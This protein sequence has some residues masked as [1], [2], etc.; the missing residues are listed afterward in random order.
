MLAVAYIEEEKMPNLAITADVAFSIVLKAREFDEKVDQTDPDSSSNP[1]DD[2]SIDALEF[3][4]HDQTR[5][6]L[7]SAI[8]DLNDDEQLDI[9]ALI[10]L[11]RGDFTL[12]EWDDAR[13][14]ATEIGR[15]GTPRFVVGIP[16]VS[17]YL[18]EGLSLFG[19]SIQDYF[20]QH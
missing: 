12:A 16:L 5:H 9:I 20:D 18:E 7:V 2:G 10:Y 15:Q 13:Q 8:S 4:P 19:A 1:T 6:E 11:G 17:D 14:A 3:G